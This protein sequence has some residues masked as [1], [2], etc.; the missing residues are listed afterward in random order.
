MNECEELI[1]KYEQARQEVS[2]IDK[3]RRYLIAKCTMYNPT[4]DVDLCL[5]QA[6]KDM[7]ALNN[8]EQAYYTYDEILYN[9]EEYCDYCK[10]AYSIKVNDLA[11]AK[12]DFGKMKR[13]I[14]YFGKKVMK[15]IGGVK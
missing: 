1:L 13:R 15:M 9:G 6:H 10:E 11:S 5:V 4:H 12:S 14:S 8:E 2:R 7:V 3:N